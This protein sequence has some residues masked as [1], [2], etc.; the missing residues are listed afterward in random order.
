M[1]QGLKIQE[2]NIIKPEI[3]GHQYYGG[4]YD[5][6][7]Y[8][9]TY[10]YKDAICD[11][12]ENK[13]KIKGDNVEHAFRNLYRAITDKLSIV[14]AKESEKKLIDKRIAMPNQGGKCI[15]QKTIPFSEDE[16]TKLMKGFTDSYGFCASRPKSKINKY[17]KTLGITKPK[18]WE[19]IDK[20]GYYASKKMIYNTYKFISENL[21]RIKTI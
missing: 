17:L 13:T 5:Y 19:F 2:F 15:V 20:T 3:F 16:Y 12:Y 8:P 7:H 6:G 14:H 10:D 9:R 1:L 11:L 21:I 4:T 18:F